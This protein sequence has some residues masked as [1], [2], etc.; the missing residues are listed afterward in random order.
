MAKK[1]EM[2]IGTLIIFIALLLVAAVA[3]GVLIQTAGSLQERALTTGDQAKGQIST[4]VRV[5]EV[6]ASNGQDG[7]LEEIEQIVKLS[8]GSNAIKLDQTLLTMN[9]YDRTAT[10]TY[11]GP[12]GTFE[13]NYTEG[14]YTLQVE[15]LGTVTNAADVTLSED[16]DGDGEADTVNLA[17]AGANVGRLNFTFS[18]GNSLIVTAFTCTGAAHP[19]DGTYAISGSDEIV[20]ITAGG[21]C[22]ANT[23][24]GT[25]I[26]VTPKTLGEGFFT[27]EY[28]QRGTNPV[29]GNLQTG[30]V[31]KIY[32]EAPRSVG[33]DEEVRI[34]FIPKIGTPTLTQFITPEVLSTERVYLYP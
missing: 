28:L 18:G 32:Y 9:T 6:S 22:G 7:T 16:Y 1:A 4:N 14:F 30:D 21:D 31:L 17:G 15:T 19:I 23:T 13:N 33:E 10:L 26:N 34:N 11:R 20:S 25:S 2:G 29:D 24:A 3:A 8:P 12:T 5:I 27:V